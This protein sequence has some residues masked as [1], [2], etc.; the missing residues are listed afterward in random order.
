ML[1]PDVIK[2]IHYNEFQFSWILWFVFHLTFDNLFLKNYHFVCLLYFCCMKLFT[3]NFEHLIGC[4]YNNTVELHWSNHDSDPYLII[5]GQ[6][7]FVYECLILSLLGA[8]NCIKIHPI[9]YLLWFHQ[10]FPH[11][12]FLFFLQF[13]V[14]AGRLD[15]N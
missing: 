14:Q 11:H 2:W 10:D 9:P 8:S 7:H 12:L 15:L 13:L 3:R 6:S 5:L 4:H 1:W